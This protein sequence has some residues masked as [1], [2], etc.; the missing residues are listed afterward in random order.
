MF[1]DVCVCVC[2]VRFGYSRGH[3]Q[4][5][6][7]TGDL[8][9]ILLLFIFSSEQITRSLGVCFG[10]GV[11]I[12]LFNFIFGMMSASRFEDDSRWFNR[13][14]SHTNTHIHT[15]VERERECIQKMMSK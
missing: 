2:V 12:F 9:R 6:L 5:S 3:L 15:Y 10:V 14:H 8:F 7:A 11:N 4:F 13:T 1:V